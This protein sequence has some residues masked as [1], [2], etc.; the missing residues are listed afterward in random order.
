MS[1]VQLALNVTDLEAAIS[2]YAD[3]LGTA[4]HK[5]REGY[6]NFA[7]AEP[8]LKLVLI[9]TAAAGGGTL[10]HLGIEVDSP[11][12]VGAAIDRLGA[13]GLTT[14]VRESELC[15]HAVQDKVWVSDPDGAPWEIY[16]VLD[17]AP[18]EAAPL[19]MAAGCC[20]SEETSVCC[21]PA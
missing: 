10:N 18:A 13:A 2:F 11:D 3:L 12:E 5:R 6:A 9:E 14:D 1:R 21:T 19:T 16:T 4:P 8:P 7:V 15:C 17:D 20:S